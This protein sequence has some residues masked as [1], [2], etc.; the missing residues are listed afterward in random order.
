MLSFLGQ[1]SNSAARGAVLQ[2]GPHFAK[3]S[4]KVLGGEL[5]FVLHF[6]NQTLVFDL[7]LDQKPEPEEVVQEWSLG[8]L[9]VETLYSSSISGYMLTSLSTGSMVNSMAQ[10][11]KY[12]AHRLEE[13]AVLFRQ[14]GR[15]G[16]VEFA[17]L[18]DGL[19]KILSVRPQSAGRLMGWHTI[20]KRAN[21]R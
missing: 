19:P 6:L 21:E 16:L 20:T 15:E 7:P 1:R 5:H 11:I 4:L 10:F 13:A 18:L 17:C 3:L 12:V 8:F 14:F 2:Y 9:Q